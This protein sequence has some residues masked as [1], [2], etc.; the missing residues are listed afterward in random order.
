[1]FRLEPDSYAIR[2]STGL[3]SCSEQKLQTEGNQQNFLLSNP[4]TANFSG[5]WS[6]NTIAKIQQKQLS[7]STKRSNIKPWDRI[8]N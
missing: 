8:I 5:D 1:M 6:S 7:Y 2:A 4:T 3:V